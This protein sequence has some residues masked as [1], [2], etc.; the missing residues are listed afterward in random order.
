MMKLILGTVLTTGV[1]LVSGVLAQDKKEIEKLEGKWVVVSAERDGKAWDTVKGAVRVNTGDK[2]VLT[3]KEGKGIPGTMKI[4]PSKKPKTMDMSSTEGN[5][6]DKTLLGIYEVDGDT[7]RI[8]FAEPGKE[9][10]TEFASKAG[11]VLVIHKREK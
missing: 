11:V 10:P 4:D 2:Y 3:P 7:L 1:L 6:K 5:F 9:R 8:C